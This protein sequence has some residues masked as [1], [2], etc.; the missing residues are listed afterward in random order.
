M[1]KPACPSLEGGLSLRDL[2][3]LVERMRI[4]RASLV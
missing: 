1:A 4:L 3:A 2:V